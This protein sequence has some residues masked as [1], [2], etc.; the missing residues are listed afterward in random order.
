MT[1]I[2]LKAWGATKWLTIILSAILLKRHTKEVRTDAVK[3]DQKDFLRIKELRSIDKS[4][5]FSHK[6]G[7]VICPFRPLMAAA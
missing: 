5:D 4:E 1:P 2:A 3:N 6:G 7:D